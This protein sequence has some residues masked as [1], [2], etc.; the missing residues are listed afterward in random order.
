M[1]TRTAVAIV[2]RVAVAAAI[3]YYILQRVELDKVGD[4]LAGIQW[5]PVAGMFITF[6]IGVALMACRMRLTMK[7][8]GYTVSFGRMMELAF[9]GMFFN[10]LA[11]GTVGADT[12]RTLALRAETG[13]GVA[14]ASGMAMFRLTGIM[15][16]MILAA[17]G[18]LINRWAW[19]DEYILLPLL[20]T[21]AALAVIVG[22]LFFYPRS[23]FMALRLIR[24]G[25]GRRLVERG[26]QLHETFR[27]LRAQPKVIIGCLALSISTLLV[28]ASRGYFLFLAVAVEPPVT[29]MVFIAS[30]LVLAF[31]LP[32]TFAMW[33]GAE[34]IALHLYHTAGVA[35]VSTIG[36]ALVFGR[37]FGTLLSLSG[38]GYYLLKVKK[39]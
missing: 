17:V 7:A 6:W 34:L 20:A 16:T 14:S 32:F 3:V 25:W 5:W 29:V 30:V 15:G 2:L 18:L 35:D 37:L 31:V 27:Q 13:S 19:H 26:E 22:I 38:G 11:P 39:Q 12:Y 9:V 21:L 24:W 8:I 1:K 23:V 4:T 28:W 10:N 36:A 33:G